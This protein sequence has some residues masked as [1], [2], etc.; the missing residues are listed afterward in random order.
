MKKNIIG[1]VIIL[2]ILLI[3]VIESSSRKNTQPKLS[4]EI[5]QLTSQFIGLKGDIKKADTCFGDESLS[6]GIS[7]DC[8]SYKLF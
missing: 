5:Q 7:A 6:T 8:V 2:I 4:P 3:G 1:G